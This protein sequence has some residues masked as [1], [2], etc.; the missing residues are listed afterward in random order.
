M[1]AKRLLWAFVFA[2]VTT[3]AIQMVIR[4]FVQDKISTP[5]ISG[6]ELIARRDPCAVAPVDW[7][8]DF[9]EEPMGTQ[10]VNTKIET[11]YATFN[12]SSAGASLESAVLKRPAGP[13]IEFISAKGREDR[14]FL[15]AINGKT[16]YAYRLVGV[17][18]KPDYTVLTYT[19]ALPNGSLDKTFT[20]YKH[21]PKVELAIKLGQTSPEQGVKKL[22]V[23]YSAPHEVDQT[24][25]PRVFVNRED[26]VKFYSNA[27]EI[28]TLVWRRPTL[29]GMD[30]QFFACALV[31]DT[32]AFVYRAACQEKGVMRAQ[33][34][35]NEVTT[36][37]TWRLTFYVGPKDSGKLSAVDARLSA[38]PDYGLLAPL[39]RSM[40][41]LIN[42]LYRYIPNYGLALILL[43]LLIKLL[44]LPFTLKGQRAME[45]Q[46]EMTRKLQYLNDKY[47]DDP[48]ALARERE[49]L[50]KKHG[51]LGGL[52]GGCLPLLLQ[53]PVFFALRHITSSLEL[54]KVP[55]LWF[56]D[57][58]VADP[59]YILPVITTLAMILS[60]DV[61]KKGGARQ[62]F[63]SIAIAIVMGAFTTG[64]PA[65]M[66]LF[67]FLSMAFDTVRSKVFKIV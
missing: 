62:Q 2:L 65:G 44:L 25:K 66:A 50:F 5:D 21:V 39:S 67:I 10:P 57:L 43:I 54:Y 58:S 55:F 30:T 46:G 42:F 14:A 29:F 28:A 19:C 63:S 32:D 35:G 31:A 56:P 60:M 16:P 51:G 64:L 37:G 4:Y 13:A 53:V 40:L 17:Q 34:E 8:I 9:Q 7:T 41:W 24:Q 45:Q 36:A 38:L 22:R 3:F 48:E 1:N 6:Q 59:Y 49:E 52:Q 11:D 23:F 47:R 12:F 18:E 61:R 33:L 20:V 27:D 26:R 15:V